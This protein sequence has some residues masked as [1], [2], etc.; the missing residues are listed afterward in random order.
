MSV[1][2]IPKNYQN[3]IPYL[4]VH[5]VENLMSFLSQVFEATE[6]ERIENA[7]GKIAHAEMRIGDCMVMLAEANVAWPAASCVLYVYVADID[8]TYARAM[9]A[10]ATSISE[11]ATH[12]YGDRTGGIKDP[13]GNTWWIATHVE[14]VSPEEMERRHRERGE[15]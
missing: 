4:L 7:E 1:N 9:E 5:G 15:G 10:G 11:P 3:V 2:P 12:F 6:M 14:D 13:S 8:A